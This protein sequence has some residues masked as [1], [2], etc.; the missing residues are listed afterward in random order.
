MRS[1]VYFFGS[2]FG[3]SKNVVNFRFYVYDNILVYVVYFGCYGCKCYTL[4]VLGLSDVT[5]FRER[6]DAFLH[7]SVYRILIINCFTVSEQCV[8]EFSGLPYFAG[9][10]IKP[11]G[12][13]ILS[14]LLE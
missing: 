6:D 5:L 8:V 14:F 12:F 13:P 11:C 4:V 3:S 2:H 10:F 9:N 1:W 7:P